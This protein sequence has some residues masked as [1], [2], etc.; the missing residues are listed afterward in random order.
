MTKLLKTIAIFILLSF[1]ANAEESE[2]SSYAPSSFGGTLTGGEHYDLPSWFKSSFL[3]IIEDVDDATEKEKHVLLF[4]HQEYCP[5]CAKM[6]TEGFS[7]SKNTNTIKEEFDVVAINIR[8]D[9]EVALTN[10]E[11]MSEAKTAEYFDVRFTPTI[12]FLDEYNE[13]VYKVNGYRGPEAF[14]EILSFVKG[15][16][17]KFMSLEEYTD[18]EIRVKR[19]SLRDHD[20]FITSTDLRA[21]SKNPLMLIVE[22]EYCELCDDFHK[23]ILSNKRIDR[24]MGSFNVVRLD[25][26]SNDKLIDPSGKV[27]TVNKFI[28]E[29][30]LTYRPGVVLFDG[31]KEIARID[32]LLYEYH[33]GEILRYVGEKFYIKYPGNFKNYLALRTLEILSNGMN[34]HLG[35]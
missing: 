19:Y 27:T 12:I 32:G 23:T 31:Y 16:A 1:G 30:G 13:V 20:R 18:Q 17:Y 3:D 29:L 25:A 15:K 28:K 11:S 2:G 6:I 34:V 4:I 35:Q 21:L 14:G 24:L 9:K 22:D 33:F 5:Y 26:E 10:T 8:G 7:K